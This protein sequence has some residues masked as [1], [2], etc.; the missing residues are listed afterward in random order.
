MTSVKT[1]GSPNSQYQQE[2]M[3]DVSVLPK[4]INIGQRPAAKIKRENQKKQVLS[5]AFKVKQSTSTVK[6]K[7]REKKS[8][9]TENKPFSLIPGDQLVA[10]ISGQ[11]GDIK[12][13]TSDGDEELKQTH[14]TK[15]AK[16]LPSTSTRKNS[17]SPVKS[18]SKKKH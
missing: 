3:I 11:R 9:K 16:I 12:S 10:K 7:S 18:K 8:E 1:P 6:S 4:Q 5:S 2:E 17:G 13:C 14:T 15:S